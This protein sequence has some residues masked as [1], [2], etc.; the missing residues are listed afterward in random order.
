MASKTQIATI[1]RGAVVYELEFISEDD[2][3]QSVTIIEG[4]PLEYD[5]DATTFEDSLTG[6]E[7]T[8]IRQQLDGD[9]S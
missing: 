2:A 3:I 9:L 1:Q 8:A 4:G 7:W 5:L 6:D